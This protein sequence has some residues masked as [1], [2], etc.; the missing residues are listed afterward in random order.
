MAQVVKNQPIMQECMHA[1]D[2]GLIP[3]PGR[4]LGEGNGNPLQYSWGNSMDKEPGGLQSWGCKESDMIEELTFTCLL[5]NLYAGQE[6]TVRNGHGTMDW[7]TVEKGICQGSTLPP[8]LFNFYTE[9]IMWNAGQE[10][11]QTGVKIA[12]RNINK[13][14][15]S[16]DT[17]LM[18]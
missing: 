6:A 17:I 1:R 5:R 14:R 4:S 7:F 16:D 12:G 10:D 11:S 8:C 13:L 15:Y 18:A 2:S 9:H 3:G